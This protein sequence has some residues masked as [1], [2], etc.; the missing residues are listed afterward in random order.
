MSF[1]GTLLRSGID[2][3]GIDVTF[4]RSDGVVTFAGD[5]VFEGS[6][7]QVITDSVSLSGSV[8]NGITFT[9]AYTT[10]AINFDGVT[11][12]K[13]LIGVGSYGSPVDQSCT[14]ALVSM[15]TTSD[16]ANSW[17]YSAGLYIKGTGSGTKVL[18]LGLQ[19][20]Y[21]GT[22]GV[23]RLQGMSSIAFLGAG[24][25]AARLLTKGGDGTAGMYCGWFKLAVG[26]SAI[27]DSG[28]FAACLWLD[29][30]VGG[31]ISGNHATMFITTGGDPPDAVMYFNASTGEDTWSNFLYFDSTTYN[32]NPVVASGCDVSGAG[33][34]E[35]YLK[36]SL[37]GTA[38]GIPLIS[39]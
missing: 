4:F 23:D 17:R 16:D 25:E 7:G 31:T 39:I 26:A 38:Y 8:A 30:Q 37:N 21:N 36:V 3:D 29:S 10:H 33:S 2:S 18:G 11:L 34:S 20:E 12:D 14:T 15:S 1:R 6:I 35:A 19:S 27:M 24:G 28:S 32:V 5:A 22:V 13:T 9:G